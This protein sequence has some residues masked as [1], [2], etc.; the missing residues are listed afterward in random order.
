M[1]PIEISAAVVVLAFAVSV[2]L[3]THELAH[4]AVL[5]VAGVPHDVHWFPG[6][7]GSVFRAGLRGKWA[8]VEPCPVGETPAWTLRLSATMPLVMLA[9]LALVPAGLVGDPFATEGVARFAVLGWMACAL[10][11]PQDFS[12][13]WYADEALPSTGE[14]AD[15]ETTP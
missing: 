12:V 10:P 2:G 1:T 7:E 6:R 13:L 9:P 8:A 15:A 11:S 3:V 14:E 4:A 5:R